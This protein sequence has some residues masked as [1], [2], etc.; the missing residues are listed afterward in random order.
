MSAARR[1]ATTIAPLAL[2]GLLLTSAPAIAEPT[3]ANPIREGHVSVRLEGAGIDIDAANVTLAR[4]LAE[5][6]AR[7]G[8]VFHVDAP[9]TDL[10]SASVTAL[11]VERALP[12]LFPPGTDF[13]FRYRASGALP[14]EVW[15]FAEGAR[16]A[17][18]KDATAP[19]D[20]TPPGPDESTATIALMLRSDDP[21]ARREGLSLLHESES[22]DDGA[23]FAALERAFIDV[24][25]SVRAHA[26]QLLT[27]LADRR[28]MPYVWRAMR[29]PDPSIRVMVVETVRPFGDGVA[30][31]RAALSDPDETVRAVASARLRHDGSEYR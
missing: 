23:V 10:V 5:I 26:V 25:A 11:A 21:A 4:V 24:D 19:A 18:S 27:G 7:T 13:T 3:D 31:L 20:P 16:A 1:A 17:M 9:V 29:D 15:I 22:R 2:V 8:I 30:L 14:S 28:A 6:T 12:R